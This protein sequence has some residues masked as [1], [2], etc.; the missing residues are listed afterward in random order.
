MLRRALLLVLLGAPAGAETVVA[1]QTIRPQQIITADL[2]RL[3]AAE[4]AGAFSSLDAVLGLEARRAI[5]PGRAVMRGALGTPA[6]VDRN[7]MVALIY[8]Y[9]G[10]RI[11]AEGRALGRGAA[12]E[13][14]RVMNVDSRTTLFGTIAPD[15]SVLVQK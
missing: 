9:G 11:T 10:L 4:V 15:G 2:V 6:L 14:I 1:T 13:R 5:Y 3:D 12:G 8:A 7:Q